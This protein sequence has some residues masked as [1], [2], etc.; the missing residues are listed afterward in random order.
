MNTIKV[1]DK[2][3]IL[4]NAFPG[5]ND[6]DDVAARGLIGVVKRVE[7]D[8]RIE[9]FTDDDWYPLTVDEVEVIGES[10]E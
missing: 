4:D 8:G 9:V 2:V 3:R 5:S 6:P 1:N 7:L 10:E